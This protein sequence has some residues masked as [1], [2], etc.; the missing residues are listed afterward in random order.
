MLLKI[1]FSFFLFFISFSSFSQTLDKRIQQVEN[2]FVFPSVFTDTQLTRYNIY[3]QLKKH[4]IHGASIAVIHQGKI[5]WTKSYGYVDKDHR[6]AVSKET[7]FQSASIGK[8]ITALVALRLVQEG[9]IDLDEN[10]NKKLKRWKVR[11]NEL[12]KKQSVSLRHLLSHGSGLTDDYGFL[13]YKP[14]DQIPSL[15]QILSKSSP[16]KA[17]K[18]L[19]IKTTPGSVERYSGA[20][21]LIVQLL[22]EDVSGLS[23]EQCVQQYIFHPLH[24][25]NSTY[26]YRPDINLNKEI[27][28]GH[29]G[30]GKS[31]KK[32]K[33]HIYPEKGAAGPWTTAEDLA[34]L[35]IGIQTNQVINEELTQKMMTPQIN[36]KGLGINLKGVDQPHAFWHAGQ[37]LGYTGLLYGLLNKGDGAVILLNSDG[38]ERFMQEFISSVATVYDWP[39]MKAYQEQTISRKD[40]ELLLGTYQNGTTSLT[41][42]EHKGNMIVSSTSSKE[43]AQLLKISENHYTFKDAQDYYRLSFSFENG[44]VKELH[45]EKSIGNKITLKKI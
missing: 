33:Y 25:I 35:V 15:V 3:D 39:I 13:G 21:Y 19:D 41:I 12:T 30:N 37:N 45:Y 29:H 32:K 7:L 40:R 17:K 43:R 23:F 11:E 8:I 28:T 2:G 20:G 22:I 24:M 16:A 31:L 5:D 44:I 4:R 36:H 34:K 27:A 38:G 42:K 26:E 14:K 18:S 6:Q 10:V 1:I 9:K